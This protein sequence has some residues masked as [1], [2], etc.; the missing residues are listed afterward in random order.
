LT[1]NAVANCLGVTQNKTDIDDKASDRLFCRI[2]GKTDDYDATIFSTAPN[3]Q[4]K[5]VTKG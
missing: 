4:K 3:A 2:A 1:E 5:I